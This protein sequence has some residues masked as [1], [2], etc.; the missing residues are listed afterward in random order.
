MTNSRRIQILIGLALTLGV[1]LLPLGQWGKANSGFGNLMG[2]EVLWWVAVVA[3][4]LYIAFVERRPLSS[5]GLRQPSLS[6]LLIGAVT[7]VLMVVGV[8]T[9][10]FVVFPMLHLVAAN[11][12]AGPRANYRTVW[13]GAEEKR[14]ASLKALVFEFERRPQWAKTIH[15]EAPPL[16]YGAPVFGVDLRS[17]AFR[18]NYCFTLNTGPLSLRP[19]A[20]PQ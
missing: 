20:P 12:R 19:F 15:T 14:L 8:I 6:T 1:A 10:F 11:L 17:N 18:P 9:I 13:R 4:L 3:I 5:I 16:M 2:G 7:G